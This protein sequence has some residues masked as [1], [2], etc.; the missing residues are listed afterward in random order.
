MSR[1]C[2]ETDGVGDA[3][4]SARLGAKERQTSERGQDSVNQHPI[5]AE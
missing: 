2:D 4:L 3:C 1:A 5:A